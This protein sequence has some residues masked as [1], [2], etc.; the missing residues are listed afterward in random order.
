MVVM[1]YLAF[2]VDDDDIKEHGAVDVEML[3]DE[4]IA[5]LN[6]AAMDGKLGS[7]EFIIGECPAT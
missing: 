5:A 6:T 1:F 7:A 2:R 4:V 3:R